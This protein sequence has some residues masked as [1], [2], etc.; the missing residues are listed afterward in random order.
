M[1]REFIGFVKKWTDFIGARLIV[2]IL[3]HQLEAT[4]RYGKEKGGD[5]EYNFVIWAL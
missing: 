2:K 4:E 1:I 5:D 3:C